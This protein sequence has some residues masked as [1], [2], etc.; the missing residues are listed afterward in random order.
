MNFFDPPMWYFNHLAED[1]VMIRIYRSMLQ[2][3]GVRD[4]SNQD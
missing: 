3:Y 2:M 4:E 1:E